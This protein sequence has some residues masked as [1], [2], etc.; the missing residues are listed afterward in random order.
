VIHRSSAAGD[1]M[2]RTGALLTSRECRWLRSRAMSLPS[3]AAARASSLPCGGAARAS[4]LPCG[5]AARASS[6]PCGGA[7]RGRFC[8]SR[9][10]RGRP[11]HNHCTLVCPRRASH[12][13]PG[14]PAQRAGRAGLRRLR[15]PA[16]RA[17]RDFAHRAGRDFGVFGRPLRHG[18]IPPNGRDGP[19]SDA[20]AL[21]PIGRD[22]TSASSDG[23]SVTAASRL[24]G[25]TGRPQTPS[26][27]RPSGGTGLRRLRTAL[28]HGGIPPGGRDEDGRRAPLRHG[29][30]P[31]N[32]R[33]K[34][35]RRAPGW[36]PTGGVASATMGFQIALFAPRRRTLC[37]TNCNSD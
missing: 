9:S 6:L 5:G 29:G 12:L 25:G 30:I 7:A 22:G 16:H 23:P 35:R 34:D 27:S 1:D 24:A 32:G 33:D 20:F 31:S 15:P 8:G 11:A 28:R 26:P 13:L 4:S 21:P 19:A 17:G 37:P 2:V 18:G 3:G 36:R 14:A 10:A